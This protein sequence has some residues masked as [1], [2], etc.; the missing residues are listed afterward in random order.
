MRK[1]FDTFLSELKPTVADYKYYTDF[2]KVWRKVGQ[3]KIELNILNS[4][5][6]SQNIEKDFEKLVYKYPD[7]LEAIPIL[8]A[9]RNHKIP[10]VDGEDLLIDFKPKVPVLQTYLKF[11][12]ETGLFSM[13][14]SKKIDNLVDYVTGVEVGLD[15]NARKNRTGTTMENI[16]ESFLRSVSELD[17]LKKEVTKDTL[18]EQYSVNIDELVSSDP[19][20]YQAAKRFDFVAKK[21]ENIFLIETNFYSSGGSKLNETARSYKSLGQDID[22]LENVHFLWITDGKGWR[23]AQGI[24][25]ETFTTIEHL[26]NIT[27]LESGILDAVM[28]GR[29]D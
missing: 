1:E 2:D 27:D 23:T 11:M 8:L 28:N 10:V 5:I 22:P 18:L 3:Y 25:R 15:S 19:E 24:L 29:T 13:M 16:V 17:D 12:R 6:G 9:V 14:E 4:L 20:A 26:Y 21:G 7:V